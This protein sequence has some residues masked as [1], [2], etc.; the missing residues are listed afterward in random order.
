MYLYVYYLVAS[1]H[2]GPGQGPQR[3]INDFKKDC[4]NIFELNLSIDIILKRLNRLINKYNKNRKFN[5]KFLRFLRNYI[6]NKSWLWAKKKHKKLG[7][8]KIYDLYFKKGKNNFSTLNF[9]NLNCHCKFNFP[10]AKPNLKFINVDTNYQLINKSLTNLGSGI[11]LF[12]L[13]DE[14]SNCYIGSA[15]NLKRRFNS[16][17]KSYNNNKHPKFYSCVNKYSWANFGFQ[18]IELINNSEDL[19]NREQYWLDILFNCPFYTKNTLN[20]SQFSNS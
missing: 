7:K 4:N 8:N 5:N 3:S 15:I 6:H 11:Y 9:N 16:H 2:T 1:P 18:I 10:L 13:L 17:Y 19:L 20:I 14:P 12:W